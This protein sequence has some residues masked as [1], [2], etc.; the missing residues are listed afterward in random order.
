MAGSR[1]LQGTL[2][3]RV[4]SLLH[5]GAIKKKP[6]W[7]EVVERFPPIV[8]KALEKNACRLEDIPNLT[9]PDDDIKR[10]FYK[11]HD[12]AKRDPYSLLSELTHETTKTKLF[13]NHYHS[14][15]DSGLN[16]EQALEQ[17]FSFFQNHLKELRNSK[18]S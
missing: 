10:E 1:H 14:L 18:S 17:S 15:L 5:S 16:H 2:I 13:L 11:K 4:R 6:C 8:P 9:Y 7:F 12:R 3:S